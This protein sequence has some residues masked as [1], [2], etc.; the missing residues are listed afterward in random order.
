VLSVGRGTLDAVTT[1]DVQVME[2][3]ESAVLDDTVSLASGLSALPDAGR[4][5]PP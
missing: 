1:P 3:L 4:L 2:R 5:R